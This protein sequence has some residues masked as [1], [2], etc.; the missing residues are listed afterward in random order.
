MNVDGASIQI[1]H[2]SAVAIS[3]SLDLATNNSETLVSLVCSGIG[4][5]GLTSTGVLYT[6]SY[7]RIIVYDVIGALHLVASVKYLTANLR[8]PED[9]WW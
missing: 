6:S 5:L 8:V 4:A 1:M 9:Y 3:E 7:D 2:V